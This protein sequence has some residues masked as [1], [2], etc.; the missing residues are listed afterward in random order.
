MV[1]AGVGGKEDMGTEESGIQTKG[2]LL[3]CSKLD[4]ALRGPGDSLSSAPRKKEL[5]ALVMALS[6]QAGG[7]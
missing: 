7:Q 2:V 4:L 1:A 6:L 5:L 3:V